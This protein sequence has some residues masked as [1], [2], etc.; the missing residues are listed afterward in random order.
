MIELNWDELNW[1]KQKTISPFGLLQ[2]A[3]YVEPFIFYG[4]IGDILWKV[5]PRVRP[6]FRSYYLW[7]FTFYGVIYAK[8]VSFRSFAPKHGAPSLL[9]GRAHDARRY[10]LMRRAPI[11]WSYRV[12]ISRRATV[13]SRSI[14]VPLSRRSTVLSRSIS[15]PLSRRANNPDL[16]GLRSISAPLSRRA[17]TPIFRSISAPLSRRAISTRAFQYS[18]WAS[19]QYNRR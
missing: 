11:F 13:L 16:S 18:T 17:I 19:T 1:I 4:L 6:R 3:Y 12:P 7:S 10:F 9:M 14:S 5:R 8:P 2:R 15:V